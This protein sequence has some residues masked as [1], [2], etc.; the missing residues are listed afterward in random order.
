MSKKKKGKK[1]E[2]YQGKTFPVPQTLYKMQENIT[3]TTNT[4]PNVSKEQ[5]I[6]QAIKLNSQGK[7]KE[8]AKYYQLFIDKGYKDYR[9]F[10]NYGSIL[11]SLRKLK[12]AEIATREAIEL[13]PDFAIAHSNLGGILKDLGKVEEAEV[14]TRKAIKLN[15][16]YAL[17]HS[18]LGSILNDLGKVKEAEVSTRK[19]LALNPNLAIT[20]SN[21]GN[22]LRDLGKTDEALSC[23]EKAINIDKNLDSA[24]E[25]IGRLLLKKGNHMD[26]ILK[27]REAIGSINFNPKN[28]SITIN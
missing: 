13:N 17:A 5:I 24:L 23:Y 12:E 4:S 3:I 18:N 21:L 9:V 25:G 10:S 7:Y 8:A 26:G 28:S 15:P 11:K 20:Y 22:I 14:S 6:N 16:D 27:L 2:R 1:E 19:A